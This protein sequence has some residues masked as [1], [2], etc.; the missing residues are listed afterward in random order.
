M[1]GLQQKIFFRKKKK[2]SHKILKKC[3]QY[4]IYVN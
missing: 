4:K 1:L 3:G 2:A